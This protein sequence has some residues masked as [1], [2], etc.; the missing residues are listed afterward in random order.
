MI[1]ASHLANLVAKPPGRDRALALLYYAAAVVGLV[2]ATCLALASLAARYD[3]Y[4]ESADLLA[5]LESR[6]APQAQGDGG[7]KLAIQGSPFLEATT[8]TIAG[9][10]L[11]KHVTA[12]VR[13]GKGNVLSSQVDLQPAEGSTDSVSL[14]ITAE[15]DQS[16]MQK[17]LYEIEAGMPLLFIDRLSIQPVPQQGGAASGTRLRV[18]LTIS[19]QWQQAKS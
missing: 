7:G 5:R 13:D 4:T 3:A 10:E 15:L 2:V 12:L 19:G 9:A 18:Q 11:Q 16:A 14:T 8:L 17:L 6:R 1:S